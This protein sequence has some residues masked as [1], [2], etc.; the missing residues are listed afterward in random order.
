MDKTKSTD[1]V[2]T[3]ENITISDEQFP[4]IPEGYGDIFGHAYVE[5][6]RA[7]MPERWQAKRS[8]FI[9]GY[10]AMF[11][12]IASELTSFYL[13]RDPGLPIPDSVRY[14]VGASL[15]AVGFGLL[16]LGGYLLLRRPKGQQHSQNQ[17]DSQR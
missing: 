13:L 8:D 16:I 15:T 12:S 11:G 10:T 3:L 4:K 2:S 6:A 17:E 7:A 14:A 1:T 9:R 5:Q